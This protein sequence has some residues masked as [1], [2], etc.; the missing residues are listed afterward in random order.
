MKLINPNHV[1]DAAFE[2]ETIDRNT[3]IY[4]ENSKEVLLEREAGYDPEHYTAVY[5]SIVN[6]WNIP[7]DQEIETSKKDQ[8]AE[9]LKKG[10][11]FMGERLK[12]E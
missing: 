6:K 8:I 5:L 2:I 3:I 4:R 1:K 7:K 9:N 10:F 11:D 12:I